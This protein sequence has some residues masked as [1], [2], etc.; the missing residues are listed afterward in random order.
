M[1]LKSYWLQLFQ[2]INF[3]RI[4]KMIKDFFFFKDFSKG[5]PVIRENNRYQLSPFGK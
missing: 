2:H 5:I 1:L 4:L 3:Q